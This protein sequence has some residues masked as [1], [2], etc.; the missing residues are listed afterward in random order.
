MENTMRYL[1]RAL[2]GLAAA[3]TLTLTLAATAPAHASTATA[4]SS[5]SSCTGFNVSGRVGTRWNQL[6]GQNSYLGCPTTELR[7]V[8]LG[9]VYAGRRQYF[10]KGSITW[11]PNQGTN[12]TVAAWSS[13]GY[14]YFDWG[15]TSPFSYERFLVRWYSAADPSGEQREF[16]GGTSGRIRVQE[17]TTGNY[18]FIVEGC[19]SSCKQ[20]W[21]LS[22]YTQ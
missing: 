18:R 1:N 22:A 19:D 20:G 11:S 15:S 16:G 13:N 21:T 7:D 3:S 9:G 14:A 12:M 10:E 17:R 6:G 2:L 8:Y 5:M 4:S